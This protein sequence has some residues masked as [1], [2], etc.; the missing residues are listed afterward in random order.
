M[1]LQCALDII[2]FDL[3]S[4]LEF[5]QVGAFTASCAL[6]NALMTFCKISVRFKIN[7]GS[8]HTRRA[9]KTSLWHTALQFRFA[10]RMGGSIRPQGKLATSSD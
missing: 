9:L 5:L 4:F 2:Q 8:L 1:S 10:R 3:F 7:R 6:Y